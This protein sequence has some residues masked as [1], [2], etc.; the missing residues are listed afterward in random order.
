M[1]IFGET[2]HAQKQFVAGTHRVR[3]PAETLRDYR[4]FMANMGITRL[5]NV[6]GLDCIGLPVYVAVRPNSRG[7]ATSQGKGLD[8]N[9][10]KA[11]ALMES[12]EAWHGE[13]IDR[14]LR[15]E[16]YDEL[17]TRAAVVDVTE[18]DR[19]V[20]SVL[21]LDLPMLWIEGWDLVTSQPMWVPFDSV[22][23]N[24]VQ[25]TYARSV[26]FS[27]TNGLASGNHLLEAV[28]HGLCEVIERDAITLWLLDDDR[29]R[30]ATQID[31]ATVD[32]PGCR[33]VLE[34]LERAGVYAAL[35][36]ATS[37]LGIPAYA[38]TIIEASSRPR[39]RSMGAFSGYGCHLSPSVALMRALSE[40]VQSRLTM[41]SGSRDDLLPRDYAACSNE[42]DQRRMLAS[43]REP[44]PTRRWRGA[45]KATA[46]FEEDLA[47]LVTALRAAG[48]ASAVVVDLA[49]PDVGIPVVKVVVPGLEGPAIASAYQPGRRAR[50]RMAWRRTS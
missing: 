12:I 29:A 25:P 38:C 45:T 48:V 20:H 39:W 7:L 9:A 33:T 46:T 30:K 17:R 4:R 43:L 24:F 34:L 23:T 47:L 40:A 41:I 15:Y 28:T 13:R 35:W 2:H 32:D 19:R 3:P 14:P 11:S 42:D 36:D 49:Q 6:T 21:R 22:T 26:F 8:A 5:A 18:V 1:R 37:D 27:S 50:A 16:A 44:A 10:A 31:P